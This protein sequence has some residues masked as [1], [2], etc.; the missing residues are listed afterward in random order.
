MARKPEPEQEGLPGIPQ[1]K[2]PEPRKVISV[3]EDLCL[4]RDVMAGQRTALSDEIASLSDQIQEKIDEHGL[5]VYTFKDARGI[6]QD[7]FSE[8]ALKKRKSQQNPKGKP[9]RPKKGDE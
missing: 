3:I 4:E 9:G 1:E 2:K 8:R 5:A 7:V 6:L